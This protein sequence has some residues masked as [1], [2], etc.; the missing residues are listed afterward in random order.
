MIG[1]RKRATEVVKRV[2]KASPGKAGPTNDQD[3]FRQYFE[4]RFEPLP[5][6]SKRSNLVDV[7]IDGDTESDNTDTSDWGGLSDQETSPP[8]EIIEYGVNDE[9]LRANDD[10]QH[11]KAFMVSIEILRKGRTLRSGIRAPSHPGRMIL[12]LS[13]AEPTAQIKTWKRTQRRKPSISNMI[14]SCNDS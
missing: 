13:R 6:V 9:S 7:L 10:L 3:L 11:A 12:I 1:K 2:E 14:S 4:T 8:I 5:E